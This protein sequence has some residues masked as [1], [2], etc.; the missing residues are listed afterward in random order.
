M[1]FCIVDKI[2][3]FYKKLNQGKNLLTIFFPSENI[4]NMNDAILDKYKLTSENELYIAKLEFNPMFVGK[5]SVKKG[6]KLEECGKFIK[7]KKNFSR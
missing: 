1:S 4:K 6:W 2:Y 3:E 5:I 7:Q